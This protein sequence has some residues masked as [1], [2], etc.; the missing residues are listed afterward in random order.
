MR[1]Q[2]IQSGGV[3]SD[4]VSLDFALRWVGNRSRHGS[5]VGFRRWLPETSSGLTHCVSFEI[6]GWVLRKHWEPNRLPRWSATFDIH[7]G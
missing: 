5:F 2:A 4:E 1:T 7:R 6:T 3:S